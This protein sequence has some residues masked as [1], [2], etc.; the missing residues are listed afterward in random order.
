MPPLNHVTTPI[1][2]P[3]PEAARL[4]GCSTQSIRAWVK[5]GKLRSRSDLGRS[6]LIAYADIVGPLAGTSHGNSC[7]DDEAAVVVAA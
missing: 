7:S 1:W 5:E 2:V 6:M 4:L 3:V